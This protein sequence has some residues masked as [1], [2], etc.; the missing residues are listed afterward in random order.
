VDS[1]KSSAPAHPTAEEQ[2]LARLEERHRHELMPEDG[3]C[4]LLDL[5]LR[6]RRKLRVSY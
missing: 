4:E 2:R 1:T 3:R 6:L 5:I